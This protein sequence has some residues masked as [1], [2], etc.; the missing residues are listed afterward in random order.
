MEV[1]Y[2]KINCPTREFNI[3][4]FVVDPAGEDS[5]I[6]DKAITETVGHSADPRDTSGKVRNPT[7][8]LK[9]RYLGAL[10]EDLLV[11]HL[12]DILGTSFQVDSSEFVNYDQHVD[13]IIAGNGHRITLEVRSSFLFAP[14]KSIVCRLHGVIGPYSTD[15]KPG[16]KP[17][18]FYLYAF[19]NEAIEK[20][21]FER[22]HTL[23]FASGAPYEMFLE[24]GEQDNLKQRGANYL[25]VKPMV[26]AMDA[27]EVVDAIRR[28]ASAV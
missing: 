14:R 24:K 6:V 15:V 1:I 23:F 3:V 17:K 19:I 21:S 8:L 10:A 16:E 22:Q 26:E 18:D 12:R 11:K 28:Q 25:L 13:I 7:Q 2:E 5:D 27:T 4:G 20:F 9:T